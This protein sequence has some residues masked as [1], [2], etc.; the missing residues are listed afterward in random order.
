MGRS[1]SSIVQS[2]DTLIIQGTN[3][4]ILNCSQWFQSIAD[5]R[6][7]D[8]HRQTDRQTDRH[9]YTCKD[10]HFKICPTPHCV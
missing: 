7:T 10:N 2:D 5:K 1:E 9:T 6:H 3:A 8:M 4:D